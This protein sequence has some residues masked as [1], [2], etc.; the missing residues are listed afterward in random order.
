MQGA[1]V[2]QGGNGELA[3]KNGHVSNREI[4]I[5]ETGTTAAR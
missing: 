4:T 3:N 2:N 5:T 1:G